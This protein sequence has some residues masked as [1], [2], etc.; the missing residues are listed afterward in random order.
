MAHMI[1]PVVHPG[2]GSPGE[3]EVF[4]RLCDDPATANWTIL[5]SLDI[6]NHRRQVAGEADF[7][8]IIPEKGILCLEVKGCRSLR[9]ENGC[10]YYGSNPK[11]DACGPF[12]QASDSMYSI[13]ERLLKRR[14]GLEEVVFWPGVIFPFVEVPAESEE[15][16][17]WQLI[18]ASTFV[19]EPL[20]DQVEAI[21]DRARVHLTRSSSAKWFDPHAKNPDK[22]QCEAVTAALRPDFESYE[23]PKARVL[24]NEEELRRYSQE[25]MVALDA[26]EA[27]RRVAFDGAAGTGKTLLAI[28]AARRSHAAGRRTLFLCYN[29]LLSEWLQD[30]VASLAPAVVCDTLHNHMCAVA[31]A[32]PGAYDS[33]FWEN[34]LPQ[35]A[36]ERLMDME[37][38]EAAG[39]RPVDAAKSSGDAD[40]Q[41]PF[42][43]TDLIIDEAQDVLREEYLDFL[44]LSLKGGLDEGSWRMFGDFT[45]QAIYGG[46]MGLQEFIKNRGGGAPVYSLVLNCRN[47][48]GIVE[49]TY[50]LDGGGPG[51]SDSAND[52]TTDSEPGPSLLKRV[53]RRDDGTRPELLFY[54]DAQEQERLLTETL[55]SLYGDGCR[56]A[57]I[58]ILSPR[59][60]EVS[61]AAAI[62]SQ[63]WKDRLMLLRLISHEGRSGSSPSDG[64]NHTRADGHIGYTTIQAFKGLEAPA[65]VITDIE[66]VDRE[67]VRALLYIGI[68]RTLG[69]LV[70]LISAADRDH[71]ERMVKQ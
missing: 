49:L 39:K 3:L 71:I 54:S 62:D 34:E 14:P 53:R 32:K 61:A 58:V 46:D 22:R 29:R 12:K 18:D 35:L 10:W 43:Y 42:R 25:Q 1:P 47:T 55:E 33:G 44:E 36:A 31:G 60:D 27:N 15:W 20:G 41:A 45:H 30:Q 48:P 37:D 6:A 63:P 56:G 11:P 67:S 2:C 50:S 38:G 17:R 57:D 19:A 16:H 70:L 59:R 21:I 23:S 5:H 51:A 26:M 64:Q 28:E 13:R 24:R 8:V 52:D 4:E 66:G 65:V 68:T 7:L 40:D 9:R 69:R